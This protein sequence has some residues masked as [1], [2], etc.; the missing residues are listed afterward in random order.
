MWHDTILYM[1][2]ERI[3]YVGCVHTVTDELSTQLKQMIED[4]PDY[5]IFLG[6]VTGSAELE[7]FKQLFYNHVNNRAR[8]ELRLH[9]HTSNNYIDQ[10][11]LSFVGTQPPYAKQTL[12]E[13][14]RTL[15]Q[16]QYQLEGSTPEQ[17]NE[18]AVAL[19]DTEASKGIRTIAQ[20]RY[21]GPWV[22]TLPRA[23]REGVVR[24]IKTDAEKIINLVTPFNVAGTQVIVISGNWDNAQITREHVAGDDIEVFDTVPFFRK[25]ITMFYD[26]IGS[27]ETR[28]TLHACI[29]YWE[30]QTP[31]AMTEQRFQNVI[32][33]ADQARAVGKTVIMTT[34]AQP[35]WQ[36]HRLATTDPSAGM[37]DDDRNVITRLDQLLA[38]L[39][40]DEVIYPHQHNLLVN[41]SGKTL[42]LNTKYILEPDGG[43]VRVVTNDNSIGHRPQIIATY[44]PFQHIASLDI[45][46]QQNNHRPTFFGGTRL[47]VQ[48]I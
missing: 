4:P 44:V 25:H 45:D 6:D 1:N 42:G 23:V 30:L 12:L 14:Y 33:A 8:G 24:N 19:S 28:T 5:L 48:V 18:R 22:R 32:K 27:F 31:T 35:N 16:F 34:H 47:P 2:H 46:T 29:P 36:I 3:R 21:F 38:R 39:L 10:K 13:G 43:G 37:S 20:F 26:T 40:P 7:Q 17:A 15:I 41:K 9:E 11:I